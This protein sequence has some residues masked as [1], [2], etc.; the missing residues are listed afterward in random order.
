MQAIIDRPLKKFQFLGWIVA[1]CVFLA[2]CGGGGDSSGSF[3]A[4]ST[5]P[6]TQPPT[7]PST[8][9][10]TV[11]PPPGISAHIVRIDPSVCPEIAVYVSVTDQNNE[12]VLGLTEQ[13]FQL[14][15]D[16]V[17]QLPLNV[18]YAEDISE[19]IVFSLTMD[20]TLSME[21][22][23]LLNVEEAAS[24]FVNELFRLTS[25][26]QL[27]DWGEIVKFVRQS[28]IMQ[29]F[30]N[31]QDDLIEGIE[32]PAADRGVSG[33]RLYDA[34][35]NS[36]NRLVEFRN[37][38]PAVIPERSILI[39]ITDGLDTASEVYN[40]KEKIINDAKGGGIEIITIGIGSDIDAQGLYDIAHGTGGLY[41]FAP[42]SDDLLT[43]FTQFLDNLKNQY[44]LRYNTSDP[45]S[46]NM[47]EVNVNTADGDDSDSLAYA[48]Q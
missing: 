47:V 36:I 29:E 35:V 17:E 33:T 8:L 24:Y 10:P 39:V 5:P 11:L 19:S 48:C 18:T 6:S 12:T 3:S 9:P 27:D 2:A 43:I 32:T 38:P 44:I 25:A 14:L 34:I 28:E 30:T 7:Q 20:Y 31:V 22:G 16:G 40:T 37:A 23:D 4:P 21:P 15:E 13:N 41:F 46:P 26:N 1:F 42:T 45:G